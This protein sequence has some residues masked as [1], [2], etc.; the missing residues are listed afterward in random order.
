M[1]TD[2]PS[3]LEIL[4]QIENFP[5]SKN[6][7]DKTIWWKKTY[8]TNKWK[9]TKPE[10]KEKALEFLITLL[11]EKDILLSSFSFQWEDYWGYTPKTKT[12][13]GD[14]KRLSIIS[15]LHETGHALHGAS[16]LKACAFSIAIFKEIFPIEFA[17]LEWKKHELRKKLLA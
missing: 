6:I 8:Y 3:K 17:R 9:K 5:P 2:Y 7:F 10:Q 12:F 15:T 1:D 13:H 14:K 16:E 11:L 4:N